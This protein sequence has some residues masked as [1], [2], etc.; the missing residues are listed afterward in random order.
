MEE[1]KNDEILVELARSGNEDALD[2]LMVRFKPLVKSKAKDYFLS[3][4]GIEDLVQEGMIGLYK[5]VLNFDAEKN[6]KFATFAHL[7][8][9]RQIQ[10]A[11]K[12][13]SRNKHIPLNKSISIHSENESGVS[14][15]EIADRNIPNPEDLLIGQEAYNDISE[16]IQE[17]LSKLEHDILTHY[18]E[19]KTHIQIAEAIGK[20]AKTVDNAIQRIRK[21]IGERVARD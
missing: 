17:N 2:I 8:V 11:I 14:I 9:V 20:N 18:L 5:A 12:A 21:K 16:F 3:G 6:A 19:G 15:G 1:L 10:S 13:A 4:G 7:C